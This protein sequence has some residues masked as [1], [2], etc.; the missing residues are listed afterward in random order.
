MLLSRLALA[1]TAG[2]T[3]L[4]SPPRAPAP[5]RCW[6]RWGRSRSPSTSRPTPMILI[7]SSW[8][9]RAGR[10]QLA[11]PTGT[12][13]F[14]DLTSQVVSSGGEQGMLSVALPRDHHET[15]LLYVFFSAEP[16]GDLVVAE[17]ASSGSAAD[18]ASLREVLSVPHRFRTNHN[19][20]Q[21]QFGPDG[22]LYVSTGDGGGAGDPL[23]NGQD[24]TTLLGALLRIDPRESGSEPYS[25]PADNPFVGTAN[26]PT[27]RESTSSAWGLQ[28]RRSIEAR[29]TAPAPR[30]RSPRPPAW[31]RRTP[32]RC[33]GRRRGRCRSRRSRG[34]TSA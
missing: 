5:R 32:S 24:P 33:W 18:P 34:S 27:P 25:V 13:Q 10:I 3:W 6:S 4:L 15:G 7:G 29:A 2:A 11:T 16:E 8:V 21:L 20:G 31:R 26:A 1:L 23:G 9:E 28:A 17:L 19:G 14:V 22:H 12:S 30:R